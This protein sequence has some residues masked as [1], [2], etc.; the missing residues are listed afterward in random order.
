MRC[1][2]VIALLTAG[3]AAFALSIASAA[4]GSAEAPGWGLA[5]A[6]RVMGEKCPDTLRADELT[7]L[8]A[9][10]SD[11]FARSIATSG[12]GAA[13]WSELRDKLEQSYIEKYSD[14]ANCTDGAEEE[15]E[16]L[17]EAV[18]ERRGERKGN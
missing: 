1:S 18:R 16:H 2:G 10:I 8:N 7:E 14:P 4:S 17:V 9:Y 3:L 11:D 12:K 6:A 5:I 13:W 15:A